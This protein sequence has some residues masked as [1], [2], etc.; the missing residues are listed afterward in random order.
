MAENKA[1]L[2]ELTGV[3]ADYKKYSLTSLKYP[4]NVDSL[5]HLMLFNINVN[6]YSSD[7]SK[8]SQ[9]PNELPRTDILRRSVG[10]LQNTL[11]RTN[12][13]LDINL[14][15]LGE[16]EIGKT[17]R[18]TIR[19]ENSIALYVPETMIFDD[20]QSYQDLSIFKEFGTM[21]TFAGEFVAQKSD[22]NVGATAAAVL[23]GAAAEKV[24]GA[25]GN[26]F[27]KRANKA[28]LDGLGSS[29]SSAFAAGGKVALAG[30]R[31]AGFAVNPMIEVIY[32]NPNLRQFQFDFSFAPRTQK[33][34]QEVGRIIKTFRRHQAPEFNT[35][36]G[37]QGAV[38][39]PPSEFDISFHYNTNNGFTENLNFPRI[40]TCVLKTVNTNFAP[41]MFSTFRDGSSVNITLR[42]AFQ[43]LDMITRDRVD[44]GF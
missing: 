19:V 34:A 3:S 33:E 9:R 41:N 6:Q 44:A 38:F 24:L 15:P 31:L 5:A 17:S 18:K 30:L 4:E 39:L 20:N 22:G 14:G 13:D 23:G 16:I 40:S 25:I 11:A 35:T 27:R 43:E 12:I 10:G 7:T 36:T 37:I 29:V 2:K 26:I 1:P 8:L 42:L 21:S 28:G 32:N